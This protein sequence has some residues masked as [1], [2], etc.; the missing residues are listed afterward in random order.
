MRSY[1]LDTVD[2]GI[3]YMLQENA[4]SN[5]TSEIGERVGVSASTVSNRINRLEAEGVITGYHPTIN[6]RKTGFSHHLVLAGTVPMEDVS[7]VAKR[8]MAIDGVVGVRELMTNRQNMSL[9]VVGGT[10]SDIESTVQALNAIDVVV[11]GIEMLKRDRRQPF[12]HFG[13]PFVDE[14]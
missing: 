5:T 12:D 4:R 1:D 10:L 2:K 8:A 3:L 13:K 7:H 9:E 6:F 14:G 11:E